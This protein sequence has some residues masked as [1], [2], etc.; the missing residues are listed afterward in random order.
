LSA[1]L[2]EARHDDQRLV[3]YLLGLLPDADAEHLDELSLS[4]DELASRL[5]AAE[6]D[7]V[8]DYVN[9]A[10]AEETRARFESFYL[11]SG[12]RRE[13]VRFARA[14]HRYGLVGASR[15]VTPAPIVAPAPLSSAVAMVCPIDP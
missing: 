12:R 8:D 2:P 15:N 1:Q 5:R 13:K 4:D 11:W 3:R 7:L 10:L 9:G 6:N 14:L